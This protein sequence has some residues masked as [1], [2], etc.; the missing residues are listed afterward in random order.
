MKSSEIRRKKRHKKITGGA[1]GGKFPRVTIFRSSKHIYAS[2]VS[3][4]NGE[5][6]FSVSDKNVKSKVTKVEKAK[7]VG[8]EMAQKAIERKVKK[9]V[10]DRAG[11]LYHG[12]V[13]A[14]A[15]GAREGGLDF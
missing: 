2:L 3:E 12:R 4:K 7:A 13:K 15:E 1:I 11:Y 5:M 14:L 9:V 6:L 10:F 8:K